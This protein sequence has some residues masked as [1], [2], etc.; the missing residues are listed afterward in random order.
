MIIKYGDE[1]TN[2]SNNI[3]M[4]PMKAIKYGDETSLNKKVSKFLRNICQ[5]IVPSLILYVTCKSA[6]IIVQN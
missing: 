4:S 1:A 3:K 2:V 6:S 5:C